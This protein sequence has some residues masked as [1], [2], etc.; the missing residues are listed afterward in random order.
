MVV[1]LGDTAGTR[2]WY[3]AGDDGN[4]DLAWWPS[5][6]Q[7]QEEECATRWWAGMNFYLHKLVL[8]R[9]ELVLEDLPRERIEALDE[10]IAG[11]TNRL[12]RRQG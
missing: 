5:L 10:M 4:Y 2:Y 7:V 1:W 8:G 12:G 9:G 6:Q 11:L 3:K